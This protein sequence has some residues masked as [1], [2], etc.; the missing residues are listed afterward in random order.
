MHEIN[1]IAFY[2]DL[3]TK[4]EISNHSIEQQNKGLAD[5]EREAVRRVQAA[6]E[7]EFQKYTQIETE[8]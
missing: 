1:D 7:E 8:K 5:K 3:Q 6:R 2:T 4:L